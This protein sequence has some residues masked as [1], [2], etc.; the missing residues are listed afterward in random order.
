[1]DEV[2]DTHRYLMAKAV[3]PEAARLAIT[4]ESAN[5]EIAP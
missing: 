4:L 5:A 1:L 2:F 3:T